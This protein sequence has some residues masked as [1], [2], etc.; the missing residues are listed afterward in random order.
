MAQQIGIARIPY[1]TC[2]IDIGARDIETK[3]G[4]RNRSSVCVE[5]LELLNA[6]SF[7]ARNTGRIGDEQL[8]R[9]E[10]GILGQK[11]APVLPTP[12]TRAI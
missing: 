8:H 6:R 10:I 3:N 7:S 2:A 9:F 12:L 1:E 11:L 5:T 4:T